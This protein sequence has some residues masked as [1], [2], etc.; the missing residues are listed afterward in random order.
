MND[1]Q[2]AGGDVSNSPW[3]LP[4]A[5]SAPAEAATSAAIMQFGSDGSFDIGQLGAFGME[6]GT[7]VV[8]K[9]ET[10]GNNVCHIAKVDGNTIT[11]VGADGNQVTVTAGELVDLYKVTKELPDTIV[12]SAGI[13]KI[14][15]NP[16]S[17]TEAI[18]CHAKHMLYQA[19]RLQQPHV[20]VDM[21]LVKGKDMHVFA[22]DKYTTGGLK[23]V[24]YSTNLNGVA[25]EGFDK[26]PSGRH[27]KLQMRL[28]DCGE[29]TFI[30]TF[31]AASAQQP[32][33]CGLAFVVPYWLVRATGDKDLANMGQTTL[34]CTGSFTTGGEESPAAPVFI[35]ILQNTKLLKSGDELLVYDKKLETKA[36]SIEPEPLQETRKRAGP[37]ERLNQP[38][39]KAMKSK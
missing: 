28:K 26:T 13:L 37:Q 2:A 3:K 29:T 12:R 39:K 10:G 11:L 30:V 22:A 1:V 35:P 4:A 31:S 38:R 21:K 32:R 14:Q 8:L 19:F 25:M 7:A 36:E 9:A 33:R 5:E 16:S 6:L 20:L 34:K 18:T 17:R 27:V 15:D 23:L 24:P